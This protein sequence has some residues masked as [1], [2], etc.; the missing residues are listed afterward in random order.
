MN[1]LERVVASEERS[2]VRTTNLTHQVT[3]KILPFVPFSRGMK[4]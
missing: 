3:W 2:Q 4:E 1:V